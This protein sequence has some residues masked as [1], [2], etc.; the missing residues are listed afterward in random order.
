L[1]G[2]YPIQ[3][4]LTLILVVHDLNGF[5]K[6]HKLNMLNRYNALFIKG[7]NQK[8]L[9]VFLHEDLHFTRIDRL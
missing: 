6:L 8:L 9:G 4:I 1:F 5:H 3:S 2:I 7:T